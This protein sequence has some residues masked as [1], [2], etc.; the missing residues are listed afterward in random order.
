MRRNVH[1]RGP[2]ASAPIFRFAILTS[3]IA[4]LIT[5]LIPTRVHASECPLPST[6]QNGQ[7]QALTTLQVFEDLQSA[8][9]VLLGESHD[10]LEHHRW[11][12]QM[13]AALHGRQPNL[14]IGL[15][16]L[17]RSAQPALDA[18][19]NGQ[20]DLAEFLD[21][22]RWQENWGYDAELY[23]PIFHYARMNRIPIYALNLDRPLIRRIMLEGWDAV[24]PGER[25]HVS[26]PIAA[27]D[28]YVTHLR[29]IFE[30]HPSAESPEAELERFVA[31]Q[32]I[33]DR[34]MAEGIRVALEDHP[35]VVAL[36]GSGHLEFGYGVPHQLAD[37]GI[38]N[39]R[40]VMPW[41]HSESCAKPAEGYAHA[42]FG[43]EAGDRFGLPAPLLLGVRIEAGETGV[44]VLS[45]SADSVAEATGLKVGDVI[46]H[47][48]QRPLSTPSDLIAI[49]RMQR[50]GHVLPLQIERDGLQQEKL[51]RFPWVPGSNNP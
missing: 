15:E 47:A 43:I 31:G 29:R 39:T 9:V 41:E 30:Y 50:P 49:V 48:A 26:A 3:I 40:W 35:Y 11:Q 46:T 18:W 22:S 33:W 32:L 36:M 34:A 20:L 1:V 6:W 2:L 8:R 10:R 12:L 42:L 13:L 28:S 14:A 37:L 25:H 7:G 17:P 16:M 5:A 19:V 44:R 38:T 45:V 27:T 4:M 23:L 21:Q 51:A 24:P